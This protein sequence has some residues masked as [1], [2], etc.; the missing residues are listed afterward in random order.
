MTTG[1]RIYYSLIKKTAMTLKKN[2][3]PERLEKYLAHCEQ[4]QPERKHVIDKIRRELE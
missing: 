3:K 4:S 2:Y 1:D